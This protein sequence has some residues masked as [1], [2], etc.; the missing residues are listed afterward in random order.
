VPQREYEGNDPARFVLSLNLHRRHLE[1]GQR[2]SVGARLA[3]YQHG[4]NQHVKRQE[5]E[6]VASTTPSIT[7]A[8]AADVMQ[9][10]R[11]SAQVRK[12][13]RSYKGLT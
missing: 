8:E 11:V 7:Q 2:A 5:I 6:G 12:E 10:D 4:T 9:V 13:L 1:P 3:A